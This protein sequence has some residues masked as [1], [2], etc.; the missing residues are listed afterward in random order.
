MGAIHY[1][2]GAYVCSACHTELK[3]PAGSTIRR[4]FTTTEDGKRARIVFA[5]GVEIHRCNEVAP[6]D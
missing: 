4:G 5:D 3:V 1:F 2:G 6:G